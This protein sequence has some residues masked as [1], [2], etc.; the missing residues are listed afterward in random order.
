MSPGGD[1][2]TVTSTNSKKNLETRVLK[3]NQLKCDLADLIDSLVMLN[4]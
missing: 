1:D 3:M 4:C 2:Y